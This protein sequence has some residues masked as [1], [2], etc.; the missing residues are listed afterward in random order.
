MAG[1]LVYAAGV[2]AAVEDHV[3]T[4][5][6][7]GYLIMRA[8][9]ITQWVRVA[10]HH[11]DLRAR[12]LR[13][14]GGIAVVQL[15]W[16]V[17]LV[18]PPEWTAPLFLVLAIGELLVPVWAERA[19][20][21]TTRPLFHPEHIEERYGLFTIIVLGESILAASIG[22]RQVGTEGVSAGLIV[23]AVGGL[24]LAFGAW[25]LYFDHPGHLTP[26]PTSPSAGATP[27]S[28]CSPRSPRSAPGCTSPP[29]RTPGTPTERTGSLAVAVPVA[30]FLLG[31]VLLMVAT[32]HAVGADVDRHEARRG[33]RDHG[34]RSSSRPPAVAV[35]GS[36]AV[37]VVLV[38][39]DDPR[40]VPPTSGVQPAM[41]QASTRPATTMV[42]A[43]TTKGLF[44]LRS[45]D[46]RE[47]F[48]V[49][50][51]VFPGEEV[52]STCIDT[53]GGS[54]AAVHRAR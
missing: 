36:A 28:S 45:D 46:G 40:S 25:W 53:R 9:L 54:T 14:A 47:H 23:I 5:A 8:G 22:I 17:I 2:P 38:T 49:S 3:F 33:G 15:L 30:G 42:L 26:T 51:P 34:A 39:V 48:D 10:R 29:K 20:P 13:Y 18:T 35:G 31:L 27:T 44:I 16:L 21:A 43:G 4:L 11:P 32:R 1:V 7:V 41:T 6:V 24:L 52:Y 50:E 37:V 12:S 19:A